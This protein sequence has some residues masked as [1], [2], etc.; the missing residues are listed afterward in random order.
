M[1][2]KDLQILPTKAD[3]DFIL[4]KDADKRR[5]VSPMYVHMHEQFSNYKDEKTETRSE[6][7]ERELQRQCC[8]YLQRSKLHSAF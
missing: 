2:T 3:K 8:K 6:F 5:K 1:P 7:Y 4:P